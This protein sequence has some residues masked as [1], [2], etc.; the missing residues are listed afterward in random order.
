VVGKLLMHGGG[1]NSVCHRLARLRLPELVLQGFG[2][3][4]G[5]GSWS[6][7]HWT[8]YLVSWKVRRS[9]RVG[10]SLVGLVGS[11]WLC[12]CAAVGRR[13]RPDGAQTKIILCHTC[14]V[15]IK[16]LNRISMPVSR[17]TG[18]SRPSVPAQTQ[19]SRP[20]HTHAAPAPA[21]HAPPPAMPHASAPPAM[22]APTSSGPGIMGQVFAF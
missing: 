14:G 5:T 8:R 6:D 3:L 13:G 9:L 18:V 20:M 21:Q 17:R 11:V 7:S 19:P 2:K 15:F 4:P 10:A 12:S 16:F 22:M 1:S